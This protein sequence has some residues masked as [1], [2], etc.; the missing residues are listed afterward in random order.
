MDL[1]LQGPYTS[2]ATGM[3]C[4]GAR[5]GAL[6]IAFDIIHFLYKAHVLTELEQGRAYAA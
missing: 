2:H 3:A 5:G 6:A 1:H 4:A